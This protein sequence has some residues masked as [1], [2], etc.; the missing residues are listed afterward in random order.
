MPEKH[1]IKTVPI[2]YKT[3]I[4]GSAEIETIKGKYIEKIDREADIWT[5]SKIKI[6]REYKVYCFGFWS[7]RGLHMDVI[8]SRSLFEGVAVTLGDPN[9][10]FVAN[11]DNIRYPNDF[12]RS[13]IEFEE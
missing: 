7:S 1:S 11:P 8:L 4:I 9:Y 13:E 6:D 5:I 3:E 12:Q 2:Y 10:A